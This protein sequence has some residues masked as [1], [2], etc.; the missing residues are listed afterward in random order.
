MIGAHCARGACLVLCFVLNFL[1]AQLD[2]DVTAASALPSDQGAESLRVENLRLK[3]AL[4]DLKYKLGEAQSEKGV[5]VT[6]SVETALQT[7]L[8]NSAKCAGDTQYQTN[9]LGTMDCDDEKSASCLDNL[10]SGKFFLRKDS[11]KDS[12]GTFTSEHVLAG[13]I[14]VHTNQNTTTITKAWVTSPQSTDKKVGVFGFK[15]LVCIGIHCN[16]FKTGLCVRCPVDVFDAAV[17]K[18]VPDDDYIKFVDCCIRGRR[19]YDTIEEVTNECPPE[20]YEG[21]GAFTEVNQA[22]AELKPEYTCEGQDAATAEAVL[23]AQ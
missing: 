2:H 21:G 18:K 19:N 12:C 9:V 8:T 7:R 20:M 15:R 4:F 17:T 13:R 22:S 3:N 16:V 14:F 1:E 5:T 11:G 23:K 6:T 10:S